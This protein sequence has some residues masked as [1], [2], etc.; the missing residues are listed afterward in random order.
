MRDGFWHEEDRNDCSK[1]TLSLA[2]LLSILVMLSLFMLVTKITLGLLML[3][4]CPFS[5]SS[6]KVYPRGCRV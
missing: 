1:G 2:S 6:F 5:Y 3:D 4:V